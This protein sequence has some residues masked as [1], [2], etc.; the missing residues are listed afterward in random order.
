MTEKAF[1]HSI[2][3]SVFC[4]LICAVAL[5]S[6]TWA[7][8]SGDVTS[9]DNE[10]K[11]GYCDI[12]ISVND[13]ALDVAV[14]DGTSDVYT[15]EAGKTYTVS[16]TSDG[17]VSSSYCKIVIGGNEHYTQ[18]INTQAPGNR[19]SFTLTAENDTDVQIISRWGV[20]SGEQ[21]D[22]VDGG[23]YTIPLDNANNS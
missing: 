19:I 23:V 6:A 2:A 17:N 14:K 1:M 8:F 3:V 18:Q 13:G 21:R 10:I 16:I 15:I 4:V 12:T 9:S 5:C 22:F 11:T 20:Y 7:W